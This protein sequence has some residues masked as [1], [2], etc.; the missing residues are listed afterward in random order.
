[1]LSDGAIGNIRKLNEIAEGGQ[2]ACAD[3]DCLR[4]A[5][6]GLRLAL[7]GASKP[8]Q[9]VDC[10][11]AV[12][13]EFTE[14][15]LA[16]IDKYADESRSILVGC[17]LLQQEQGAARAKKEMIRNPILPGFNPDPSPAGWARGPLHRDL[18]L[19]GYPGV[20]VHHCAIGSIGHCG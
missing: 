9:V 3:G 13:L 16:L 6:A 5:A 7:I 14:A 4:C 15:E 12:N 20:Q 18:I 10:A 19:S 2:I 17:F 11:G 8:S 1:M